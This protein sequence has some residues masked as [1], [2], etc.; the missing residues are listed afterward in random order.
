VLGIVRGMRV[1]A[2]RDPATLVEELQEA[3]AESGGPTALRFP[4]AAV[5]RT[6]RP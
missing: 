1:A 3:V 6:C 4:K 2:P 5:G